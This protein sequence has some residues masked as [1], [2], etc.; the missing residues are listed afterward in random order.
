M[1]SYKWVWTSI[2]ASCLALAF[3]SAPVYADQLDDVK[4]AGVITLATD[5]HFK[6]FDFVEDNKHVG[7]DKDL[8]TE[9]G[10]ELDID[11]KFIDLP[12][13]STLAGLDAKRFDMVNS[14]VGVTKERKQKYHFTL[15]FAEATVAMLKRTDDDSINKPE[16]ASGKAVGGQRGTFQLQEMKDFGDTL[17]EKPKV[18]SYLNLTEAYADLA[19]GRIDAVADSI[20]NL[21]AVAKT[22][23]DVFTVVYPAF[24]IETYYAYLGRKGEETDSL[25][26][27]VND[28]MRTIKDDGRMLE[29]Q[30]KWFGVEQNVPE[31]DDFEPAQ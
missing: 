18:T 12:W 29:L 13:T 1:L 5:M 27:A 31:D 24:G 28:A 16:D 21:E 3:V 20:T 30:E 23:P 25:I 4:K 14:P 22:R 6:P 8:W 17:D 15:P 19:N 7:F 9:I 2:G 26:A 10:K 11:V